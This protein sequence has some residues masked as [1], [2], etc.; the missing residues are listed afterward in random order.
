M[1]KQQKIVIVGDSPIA[2]VAYEYFT[3]DSPYEVSAFAVNEEYLTRE[4]LFGIPVLPFETIAE[5]HPPSEY[6]MFVALGFSKLNRHRARLFRDAKQKGYEL[7]SYVSSR[8]FVWSNVRMGENCFVF[9]NNV[10]QPFVTIGDNVTLW[11][12]N[13]IGHHSTIHDHCFIASHV[14]VSGFVEIGEHCFLGV[15]A[16]IANNV[17]VHRDCLIGAAAVILRDT[18]QGGI[19]ATKGTEVRDVSVYEKMGIEQVGA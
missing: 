3:H 7:V 9:E 10:I 11:S 18:R 15:N 17:T 13:H 1:K 16:T 19:Y 8:A 5:T 2:E 12:G 14:V 6:G 4:S